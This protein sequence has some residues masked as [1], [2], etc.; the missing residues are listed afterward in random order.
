VHRVR[1]A[2]LDDLPALLELA[3]LGNFINL[4]PQKRQLAALIEASSSTFRLASAGAPP[5]SYQ[6]AQ[7]LV[8][9]VL[10][11]PRG[12]I[13]G[14]SGV[15]C[16]MGDVEHPNLSFQL[17]KVV[18]RSPSLQKTDPAG[19]IGESS[20]II[21]GEIEH[22]YAVLFQDK[23]SPT[24]L[25]GNV[26]APL[27]RGGGHGKLL[28]YCRFHYMGAH[29]PFFSD[30]VMA[31]M[32]APLDLYNDGNVF[33]R[34]LA[35]R[36]INLS[37]ENADRLSTVRDRREFMY[38]LLPPMVNLSLLDDDVLQFLGSVGPY[39]RG[40]AQMLTDIGF[41]YVHRVDPFD[42]GAHL[43]HRLSRLGPMLGQM[44]P[45]DQTPLADGDRATDLLVSLDGGGAGFRAVRA[46][47]LLVD[48]GGAVRLD[49]AARAALEVAPGEAVRVTRL[50]FRAAAGVPL[51][52]PEIDLDAEYNRL[53][54]HDESH[55]HAGAIDPVEFGTIMQHAIERIQHEIAG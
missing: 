5:P 23:G 43:E 2:T 7:H 24:E 10:E 47:G 21:S 45:V 42:A 4:P 12:G 20:V 44:L 6:R 38:N 34:R 51:P 26:I 37:Y 17:L 39:T 13:I 22:T 28:S 33:W 54:T 9:F 8:I 19:G 35:R 18:R 36:F 25:G 29:A 52:V 14:S 30:R 11:D 53:F 16:G 50:D 40:A 32:M 3:Q 27:E 49:D 55:D 48:Q 41:R 46:R 1:Q 15:R 31:E